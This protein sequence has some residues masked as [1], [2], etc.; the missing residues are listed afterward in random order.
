MAG[1]QID[2]RNFKRVTHIMCYTCIVFVWRNQIRVRP[3][4][5]GKEIKFSCRIVGMQKYVHEHSGH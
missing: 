4:L 3:P 1:R 5:A 2:G